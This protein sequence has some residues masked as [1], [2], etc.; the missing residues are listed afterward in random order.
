MYAAVD[1]GGT[2]TL[3]AV[4]SQDGEIIEKIKFPTP[5]DYDDFI[6]QLAENVANLSTKEFQAVGLAL[7][8]RIDR[9]HGAGLAFGNL[10]WENVPARKDTE[11][12][13]HAPVTIENDAKL[14]GFLKLLNS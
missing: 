10:P 6:E 14:A 13:F 8:A 12:I 11:R 1:V 2:K 9:K 3:V 7:P 4:F 5:P